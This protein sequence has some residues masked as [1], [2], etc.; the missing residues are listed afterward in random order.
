MLRYLFRFFGFRFFLTL[1]RSLL[2]ASLPS[3]P[4]R[5]LAAVVRVAT[6][7]F[8]AQVLAGSAGVAEVQEMGSG[9]NLRPRSSCHPPGRLKIT[10]EGPDWLALGRKRE[11]AF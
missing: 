6:V 1:L 2:A 3:F 5:R 7:Q 8:A 4:S 11:G 10:R 9:R